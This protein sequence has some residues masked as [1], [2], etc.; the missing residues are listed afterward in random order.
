MPVLRSGLRSDP[1]RDWIYDQEAMRSAITLSRYLAILSY[2]Q[3]KEF[4]QVGYFISNDRSNDASN[5]VSAVME[6]NCYTYDQSYLG[7]S[8]IGL[9]IMF[10]I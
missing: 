10:Q 2:S 8:Q 5:E 7:K 1:A 3:L 9:S 4:A 6:H